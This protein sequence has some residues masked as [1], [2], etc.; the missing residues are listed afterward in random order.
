[1]YE[2]IDL[3]KIWESILWIEFLAIL[4]AVKFRYQKAGKCWEL[5]ASCGS[6]RIVSNNESMY[7]WENED[8]QR[9]NKWVRLQY[10]PQHGQ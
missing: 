5:F 2:Y 3:L 8:K 9:I 7:T 4:T 1:M 6:I 10:N